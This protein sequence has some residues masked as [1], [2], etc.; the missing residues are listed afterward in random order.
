MA[1]EIKQIP[2]FLISLCNGHN[3]NGPQVP[4]MRFVTEAFTM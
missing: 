4:E 3:M 1:V 2:L